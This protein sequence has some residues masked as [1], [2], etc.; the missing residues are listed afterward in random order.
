MEETLFSISIIENQR[1]RFKVKETTRDIYYPIPY[2]SW[3]Q[4]TST[5]VCYTFDGICLTHSFYNQTMMNRYTHYVSLDEILP[6]KNS[7]IVRIGGPDGFKGKIVN[8]RIFNPGFQRM[9]NR[10]DIGY[11]LFNFH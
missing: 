7:D 9:I 6:F 10:I 2:S 1:L 5:F 11:F 8:L 4:I 3:T